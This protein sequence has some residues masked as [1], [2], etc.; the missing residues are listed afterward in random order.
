MCRIIDIETL[1]LEETL[2][3]SADNH[4]VTNSLNTK[5]LKKLK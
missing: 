1:D 4:I 2:R 5:R 3:S